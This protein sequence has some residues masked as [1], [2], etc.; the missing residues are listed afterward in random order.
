M[1][2]DALDTFA[3]VLPITHAVMRRLPALVA[4]YPA[5]SARDLVHVATCLVEGIDV[6]VSPDQAFDQV[7]EI[8]RVD[9]LESA[10]TP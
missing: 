10:A 4:A 9:P 8:R 6:I 7:R 1:A 5:L 2:T 3:P